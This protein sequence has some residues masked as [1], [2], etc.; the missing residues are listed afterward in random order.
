MENIITFFPYAG[1]LT[2]TPR[3][4]PRVTF[5]FP[6]RHGLVRGKNSAQGADRSS[7]VVGINRQADRIYGFAN[8]IA[9]VVMAAALVTAFATCLTS[10][11]G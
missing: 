2:R 7:C 3:R 10:F 9:V 1:Q 5:R 8:V 11:V 6:G 4:E